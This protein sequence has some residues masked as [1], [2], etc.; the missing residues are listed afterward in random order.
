MVVHTLP[1]LGSRRGFTELVLCLSQ[2]AEGCL[3]PGNAAVVAA[4]LETFNPSIFELCVH[5]SGLRVCTE[6]FFSPILTQKQNA[7]SCHFS[8]LERGIVWPTFKGGW[9]LCEVVALWRVLSCPVLQAPS[10]DQP[11]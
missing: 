4:E 3:D 9:D 7:L 1:F 8:A 10:R 2:G 5:T 11:A 6:A